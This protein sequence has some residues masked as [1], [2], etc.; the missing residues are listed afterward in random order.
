MWYNIGRNECIGMTKEK[1]LKKAILYFTLSGWKAN[2]PACTKCKHKNPHVQPVSSKGAFCRNEKIRLFLWFN[3]V[4]K[5][6]VKLMDDKSS[7]N[8]STYTEHLTYEAWCVK[9]LDDE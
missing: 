2:L 9:W 8:R 3:S 1:L 6:D 7:M 5:K 4:T